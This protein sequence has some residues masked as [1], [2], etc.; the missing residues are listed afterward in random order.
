MPMSTNIFG[1]KT[2][3]STFI[4]DVGVSVCGCQ[5]HL[6]FIGPAEFPDVQTLSVR[7][8]S[9]AENDLCDCFHNSKVVY[10]ASASPDVKEIMNSMQKKP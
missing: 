3:Y 9:P 6:S 5:F 10:S 8:W 2:F 4:L 7:E 1:L